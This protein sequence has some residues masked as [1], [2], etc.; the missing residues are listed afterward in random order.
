MKKNNINPEQY[1]LQAAYLAGFESND[2]ATPE[3]EFEA[4]REYLTNTEIRL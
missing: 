1:I 3:E 2:K 4:A